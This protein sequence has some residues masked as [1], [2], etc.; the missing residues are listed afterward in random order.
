MG[1]ARGGWG[2]GGP[3]ATSLSGLSTVLRGRRRCSGS[4]SAS[5][6]VS[7]DA[8]GELYGLRPLGQAA[9]SPSTGSSSGVG[10]ANGGIP[11]GEATGSPRAWSSL[12]PGGACRILGSSGAPD[13]PEGLAS[14]AECPS[15]LPGSPGVPAS[16]VRGSS[17]GGRRGERG[18]LGPEATRRTS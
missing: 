2:R 6:A 10:E 9:A 11:H 7:G 15:R 12:G 18:S 3:V 16:G 14:P 5:R 13:P 8:V 17:S 4:C 1:S